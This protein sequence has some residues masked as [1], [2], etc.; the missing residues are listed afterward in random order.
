M[1]PASPP[2]AGAAALA[3]R[4]SPRVSRKAAEDAH[5]VLK[6]LLAA[7]DHSPPSNTNPAVHKVVSDEAAYAE[8]AEHCLDRKIWIGRGARK[9]VDSITYGGKVRL[10]HLMLLVAHRFNGEMAGAGWMGGWTD[11]PAV[12]SG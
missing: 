2:T 1:P 7:A 4:M 6:E 3:A 9:E 5:P 8:L 10:D 12:A 11:S